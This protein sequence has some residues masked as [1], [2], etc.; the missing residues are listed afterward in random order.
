MNDT[1]GGVTAIHDVPGDITRIGFHWMLL[2]FL[3]VTRRGLLFVLHTECLGDH[4][5]F[6]CPEFS[7]F[8]SSHGESRRSRIFWSRFFSL[9][10]ICELFLHTECRGIIFFITRLVLGP[11]D[12]R[13][14]IIELSNIFHTEC[15][16]DHGFFCP[17]TCPWTH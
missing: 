8:F 6:L 16:G 13:E 1:G 4:G 10:R 9:S 7:N 17:E 15:R 14:V 2:F 5:G 3:S 12:Q 11:T